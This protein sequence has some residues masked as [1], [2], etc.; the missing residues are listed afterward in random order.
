MAGQGPWR[1][2]DLQW[3]LC[4]DCD[5]LLWILYG[6]ASWE[7]WIWTLREPSKHMTVAKPKE[8]RTVW[9]KIV[10]F[11]TR[12]NAASLFEDLDSQR[13]CMK[14]SWK[15]GKSLSETGVWKKRSSC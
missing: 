8:A 14:L 11:Q 1:R 9:F 12:P 7:R 4:T 13:V 15:G 10:C 3:H 5:G 2:C 6:F